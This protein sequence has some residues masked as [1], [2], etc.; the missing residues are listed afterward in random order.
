M[1]K[2]GNSVTFSTDVFATPERAAFRRCG[3]PPAPWRK[4][5]ALFFPADHAADAVAALCVAQEAQGFFVGLA[6]GSWQATLSLAAV[7]LWSVSVI[8]PGCPDLVATYFDG[9]KTAHLKS[10]RRNLT[11]PLLAIRPLSNWPP[12]CVLPYMVAFS[13]PNNEPPSRAPDL[14][15][16]EKH[17]VA[18]VRR[19]ACLMPA[20]PATSA[21]E[22]GQ[23]LAEEVWDRRVPVY[24]LEGF[25]RAAYHSLEPYP[26]PKLAANALR[27][28]S[29]GTGR[30][31]P[32][33]EC[34][35]PT[36]LRLANSNSSLVEEH[37]D[38]LR[39][40]FMKN[41][42]AGRAAG[43]FTRPPFPNS[44]NPNQACVG[45]TS[46]AFKGQSWKHLARQV[47]AR[48]QLDAQKGGKPLSQAILKAIEK[49]LGLG[50]PRPI[51][52]TSAPH[53]PE[54]ASLPT[55]SRM[56]ADKTR[57]VFV[58]AETFLRFLAFAGPG[59]TIIP[60]DVQKAYNTLFLRVEDLHEYVQQLFTATHGLE[61]FVSL[62]NTFGTKDAPEEW[63][64]F[65][66]ILKWS[67]ETAEPLSALHRL[68][69]RYVDNYWCFLP[70]R[71]IPTGQSPHSIGHAIFDHI[72]S[73]GVPFHD[74]SISTEV[75]AIG[76]RFG[77]LPA[78]WFAFKPGKRALAVVLLE[79]LRSLDRLSLKCIQ[80][81]KGFLLWLSQLFKML[82]PHLTSLQDL[83]NQAVRTGWPQK[84][85]QGFRNAVTHAL[86]L[87]GSFPPDHKF[88]VHPGMLPEA[89]PDVLLRTDA[90]G[91]ESHGLGAINVT[92]RQYLCRSWT[93]GELVNARLTKTGAVS[94]TYL[95]AVALLSGVLKFAKPDSLIE[96]ETDSDNLR[97]LVESG[98]A[99]S[100]PA[101][102]ALLR[103]FEHLGALNSI[104]RAR[105][106]PRECNKSSD[107]LSH[108]PSGP[109]ELLELNRLFIEEFGPTAASE[110][111][112]ISQQ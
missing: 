5:S 110:F 8:L 51:S 55:N 67:L 97:L 52:D 23:A 59:A 104:L 44:R 66:A 49:D 77:S 33:A 50:K 17:A 54:L 102:D 58:T 61:T 109:Q 64:A 78:P 32:L 38:T 63:Q 42:A 40:L 46:C 39:E 62:V 74:H 106:I 98:W 30:V 19:P 76:W 31:I 107:F 16:L 88:F 81:A 7:C 53:A 11:G 68:I 60:F 37:C 95:E 99:R 87:F 94:S 34:G 1:H 82:R 80:S 45:R 69:I 35:F 103:I 89:I 75:E 29:S 18:T 21:Q 10:R 24:S 96:V 48:A 73:L 93:E 79:H 105:Q 36:N 4:R 70:L 90:S 28:M 91:L 111:S 25:T 14:A 26:D 71:F 2:E 41:V 6:E 47:V 112:D 108:L 9:S 12:G 15:T 22:L 43:P 84:P 100:K 57:M 56:R 101:N 13:S 20:L 85:G 86:H 3:P 65:A 27:G 92:D 72:R 83:E